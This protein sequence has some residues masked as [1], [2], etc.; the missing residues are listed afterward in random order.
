MSQPPLPPEAVELLSRPNP[1]VMATLRSDGAPVSTLTRYVWQDGRVLISPDEGRVRLK[2]PGR[3]P[4][5]T[6]SVLDGDDW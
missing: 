3:D 1:C 2:Q 6:L 5:L 4:R